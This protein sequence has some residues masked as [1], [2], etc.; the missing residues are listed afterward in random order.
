[1][2]DK[3]HK[4][5]SRKRYEENYPN[6]TARM[7]CEWHKDYDLYEKKLGFSRREFMAAALNKIKIDYS[8]VHEE[9]YNQGF[10]IGDKQGSERGYKEGENVGIK[11]GREIGLKEGK[12]IGKQKGILIGFEQGRE[13]HMVWVYCSDCRQ[14]EY[15]LPNT[16]LHHDLIDFLLYYGWRCSNCRND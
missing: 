9:G 10:K 16:G 8:K 3:K 6:W 12:E 4:P 7:P 11:K 1:M 14:L 15:A 13:C 5:P 2:K